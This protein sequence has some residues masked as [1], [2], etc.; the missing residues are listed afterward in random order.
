M[1][2]VNNS[3]QVFN[4]RIHISL[5]VGGLAGLF[6]LIVVLSAQCTR[7]LKSIHLPHIPALVSGLVLFI[8]Y[9]PSISQSIIN[10][11]NV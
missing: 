8:S 10:H 2:K 11:H 1:R 4:L 9:P 6:N 7:V 3:K 5:W